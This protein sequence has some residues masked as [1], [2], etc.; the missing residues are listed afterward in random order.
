MD[1]PRLLS[2]P[3]QRSRRAQALAACWSPLALLASA[4]IARLLGPKARVFGQE[5]GSPH[6]LG[7]KARVFGQETGS[8]RAGRRFWRFAASLGL[9]AALL[10]ADAGAQAPPLAV[11]VTSVHFSKAVEQKLSGVVTPR[12][13]TEAWQ[14]ALAAAVP[15]QVV[16][17]DEQVAAEQY[18]GALLAASATINGVELYR[19]VSPQKTSSLVRFLVTITATMMD[20][21]TG[22]VFH[23]TTVVSDDPPGTMD[24]EADQKKKLQDRYLLVA[25][26]D[27]K[28]TAQRIYRKLVFSGLEKLARQVAAQ[29]K[30]AIEEGQVLGLWNAPDGQPAAAVGLGLQ[31]GLVRG[32]IV[33][34]YHPREQEMPAALAEVVTVE[35]DR[36]VCRLLETRFGREVRDGFL[37]RAVGVNTLQRPKPGALIFQVTGFGGRDQAAAEPLLEIDEDV[38]SMWLTEDLGAGGELV[39]LAPLPSLSAVHDTLE[40]AQGVEV[41]EEELFGRR[42]IADVGIKATLV[43][44]SIL[45]QVAPFGTSQSVLKQE[46]DLRL[47]L[48]LYDVYTGTIL[49]TSETQRALALEDE[50]F[51][52]D[53][54]QL[55]DVAEGEW[56]RKL[57]RSVIRHAAADARK[58]FRAATLS[59]AIGRADGEQIEISLP[60]EASVTPK[61]LL[62]VWRPPAAGAASGR[63]AFQQK[64]GVALVESVKGRTLHARFVPGKGITETPRKGDEVRAHIS[65]EPAAGG[66]NPVV[67][68]EKVELASGL[69]AQLRMT[70]VGLAELMHGAL[71]SVGS[72]RTVP[73]AYRAVELSQDAE[74]FRDGDFNLEQAEKMLSASLRPADYLL[75]G[76][77]ESGDFSIAR[78][79]KV[80][81]PTF[82]A[83]IRVQL[84]DAAT[85][86]VVYERAASGERKPKDDKAANV[87]RDGKLVRGMRLEDMP[88][89]FQ[90]LCKDLLEALVPHVVQKGLSP[91]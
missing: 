32:S 24:L 26:S 80:Q 22:E 10:A 64:L 44:A 68:V 83:K 19:V 73:P 89:E 65:S 59:A 71:G 2:I 76:L 42:R 53:G 55:T 79:G 21:A 49:F 74:L 15:F 77:V 54:R 3:M 45:R 69:D 75:R 33:R 29:Y 86:A 12:E 81:V 6:L 48:E 28:A 20:P 37:A 84:V 62:T 43:R 56:F 40:F 51:D 67:Q 50:Q 90:F 34:I 14:K 11:K 23:Q 25:A 57:M 85:G 9:A 41:A 78:E 4:R 17:Y 72:V 5:T 35:R 31:H 66:G 63:E 52:K 82:R 18:G 70:P 30:P 39:M 36:S 91:S 16:G 47:A 1:E 7:P 88:Q 58:R 38:F 27:E 87:V 61:T 13:V 60:R 46:L 8:P